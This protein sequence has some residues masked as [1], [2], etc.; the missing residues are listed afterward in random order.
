VD[1]LAQVVEGFQTAI[2]PVNLFYC[3]IGV[4]FGTITG[5]LPGLGSPTAVALLLPLTL[6]MDPVTALIMLAGIYYG[7]QYGAT[8]SSVL[9]ATP[10]DSS[11]VV[12]TI[13]GYQLA[14]NGRAGPALA[15]AA[16]ASF[17]AGTISI[18]L[19]M[20]VAPPLA[21]LA[22]NFGPPETFALGVVG[23]AGVIGFTGASRAKGLAMA[24]LGLALATVGLDPSTGETRFAFGNIQLYGGIGFLEVTIGLFAIAELVT[25]LKTGTPDPIRARYREM[26]LTWNDWRRSRMSILRGGL[27]GFVVGTIPGVGATLASFLA[28]D[29]ERRVSRRKEEFG[30]GAIEGLAAPEAANNA[31]SN[32][33]FVPLLT[34]GIPSSATAAVLLGAFLLFGIQPGPL[35]IEEQPDVVWGLLASFY[36]GNII[37]LIMNLPLAPL[38]ASMLRMRYEMMYPLILLLSFLGAFA[39]ENR[40]WGVWLALAFGVIGYFM[41][42]YDYPAPPVILGLIIGGIMEEALV[43]TSSISGGDFTIFLSRPIALGMFAFALAII[44]GP[45][46]MKAVKGLARRSAVSGR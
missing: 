27:L 35:L 25:Q 16:V 33:A 24:A 28:Y 41:K 43:Q 5:L 2:T 9:V 6:A 39:V 20:T 42:R 30:K 37:L 31:A 4:L 8:I 3:F 32:A 18:I 21:S 40:L 14:R 38:F 46:I 13:D 26:L 10:G 34:L 22:I 15:V 17:L 44:L 23:L 36:I 1:L 12:S 19:L 45:F 7:T 11:T 29:L